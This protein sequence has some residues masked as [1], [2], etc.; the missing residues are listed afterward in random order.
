HAAVA[1]HVDVA[2]GASGAALAAD[3]EA[4]RDVAADRAGDAEAAVPAAAAD[5]LGDDPARV[6]ARR[7]DEV[8][9]RARTVVDGDVAARRAGAAAAPDALREERVG[10]G[11]GR[12]QGAD[13][14]HRD[15]AARAAGRA[16]PADADARAAA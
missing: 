1:R 2:G 7:L 9:D 13:V 6:R 15:R 3:A 12:R 10:V 16:G 11:A 14:H 5:A 8:R 4:E